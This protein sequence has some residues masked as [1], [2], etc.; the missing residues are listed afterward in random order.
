MAEHLLELLA[1]VLA[2]V[3]LLVEHD[4]D[5]REGGVAGLGEGGI[6]VVVIAVEMTLGVEHH[7]V[8]RVDR[9]DERRALRGYP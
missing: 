3:I 9:R 8:D 6:S 2:V 7:G 4:L 5:A 1:V